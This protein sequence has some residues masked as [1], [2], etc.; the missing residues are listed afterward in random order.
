MN[1]ESIGE[2][3]RF[4]HWKCFGFHVWLFWL[5]PITFE[6]TLVPT[7]H[8]ESKRGGMHW[9]KSLIRYLSEMC[10]SLAYQV[11]IGTADEVFAWI[12]A[13][14]TLVVAPRG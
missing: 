1:A 4:W 6:W 5:K 14:D 3:P 12:F 10:L 9:P 11:A 13:L 8:V 7:V 2:E